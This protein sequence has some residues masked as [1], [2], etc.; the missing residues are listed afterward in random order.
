MPIEIPENINIIRKYLFVHRMT[1][2]ELAR[3]IGYSETTISTYIAGKTRLSKRIAKTISEYTDGQIT[4]EEI[5]AENPP[6]KKK[7][8]S[9]NDLADKEGEWYEYLQKKT[10]LGC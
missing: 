10:L 2:A 8:I 9:K 6:L 4:A 5:L 3:G 1:V 7:P